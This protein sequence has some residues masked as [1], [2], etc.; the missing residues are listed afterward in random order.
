MSEFTG[1]RSDGQST[2]GCNTTTNRRRR[3]FLSVELLSHSAT[4][5]ARNTL[6]PSVRDNIVLQAGAGKTIA[7]G[8]ARVIGIRA[9]IA[10]TLQQSWKKN[11]TDI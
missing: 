11:G 1:D 4:T 2:L 6:P 8:L 3:E 9:N 10:V 7:V 5:H